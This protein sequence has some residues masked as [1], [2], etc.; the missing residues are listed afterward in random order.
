MRFIYCAL[1]SPSGRLVIIAEMRAFN[2]SEAVTFMGRS[3]LK[4]DAVKAG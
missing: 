1:H 2:R 4:A 3:A